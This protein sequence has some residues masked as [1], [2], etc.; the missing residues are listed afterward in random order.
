[1]V[2]SSTATAFF[3]SEI[4]LKIKPAGDRYEWI[5]SCRR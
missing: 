1:V 4:L 5:V 3:T 2:E